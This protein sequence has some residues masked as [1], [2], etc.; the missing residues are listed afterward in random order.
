[1]KTRRFE[2]EKDDKITKIIYILYFPK[3]GKYRIYFNKTP[4]MDK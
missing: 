1:V 2:H 3:S 4:Y